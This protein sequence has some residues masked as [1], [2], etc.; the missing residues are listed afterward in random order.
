MQSKLSEIVFS[1]ICQHPYL[2][3]LV[4]G[5][6]Q[7]RRLVTVIREL[8]A[9]CHSLVIC[10][11][12][13]AFLASLGDVWGLICPLIRYGFGITGICC[14]PWVWSVHVR[15]LRDNYLRWNTSSNPFA[16]FKLGLIT[17]ARILGLLD[18]TSDF[19]QLG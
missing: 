8:I 19:V 11:S 12:F 9:L 14:K 16:S 2:S 5:C 6:R 15:V 7:L 18:S 1:T 10:C 3:I 17:V 4:I 13:V